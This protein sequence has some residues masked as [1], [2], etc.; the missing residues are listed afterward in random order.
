MIV[1]KYSRVAELLRAVATGGIAITA[2]APSPSACFANSTASRVL[3]AP[4]LMTMNPRPRTHWH[5]R[6]ANSHLPTTPK[7]KGDLTARYHFAIGEVNAHLQAAYVY[8]SEVLSDIRPAVVVYLRNMPAY[9][10]LDL[11]FGVDKG[12]SSVEL[13]VN[14]VLDKRA[15]IY[16]Y[17][18][19]T[20]A[21][22][23]G[24]AGDVYSGIYAPRMIG[25]KFG[26]KF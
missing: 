21:A 13:F 3:S 19:C 6:P 17:T 2:L 1:A 12:R 25:V 5:T 24:L 23:G 16:R 22:C 11:T 14:N 9:G 8:Q 7:F 20:E 15:E 10:L 4:T 26:Q 18:E